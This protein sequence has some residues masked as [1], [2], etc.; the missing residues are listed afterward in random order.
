MIRSATLADAAAV[1]AIYN[2]YVRHTPVTFEEEPVTTA[3]MTDRIAEVLASGNW[4]VAVEAGTVLGYA[5]ANKWKA[6][7]A[8]RFAVESTIYLDPAAT[9]RGIGK[10]LYQALL[11][12]LRKRGLHA[13][14][15]CRTRPVWRSMRSW[16]S[17][18]S[19]TSG[20]SAGSSSSGSMSAIGNCCCEGRLRM[21][22]L[23]CSLFIVHRSDYASLTVMNE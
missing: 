6:R 7:C 11:A 13:V 16:D 8:Y 4:L 14:S 22:S 18:R 15:P 19:P 20:R 12:D 1:A 23:H 21:F 5:Y 3:E 10:E 2:H 17:P 9:G